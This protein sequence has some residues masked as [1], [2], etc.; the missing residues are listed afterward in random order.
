MLSPDESIRYL[1]FL[2]NLS[3]L[4]AKT[5]VKGTP[6]D[7]RSRPDPSDTVAIDGVETVS[8]MVERKERS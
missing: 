2:G 5:T 8:H 4:T 7:P 6:E 3:P 1:L